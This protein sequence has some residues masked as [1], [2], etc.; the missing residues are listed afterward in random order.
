MGDFFEALMVIAFGLS[1]PISILKSYRTRTATGKSLL[2]LFFILAGYSFG[3]ISKLITDN[4]TYV[5]I[6][7]VLNFVMVFVD[8]AFYF[9]NRRLDKLR[10]IKSDEEI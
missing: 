4:I 2:F 7:Y 9:R 6:F 10:K 3:I 8:G 5:F 1:W